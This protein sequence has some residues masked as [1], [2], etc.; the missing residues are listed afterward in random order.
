MCSEWSAQYT[1]CGLVVEMT[2]QG[3]SPDSKVHGANMGPIWDQQDQGGPHV[4]PIYFAI[5]VSSVWF[6]FLVHKLS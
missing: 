4:G 5:W 3:G 6:S 2:K 1:S